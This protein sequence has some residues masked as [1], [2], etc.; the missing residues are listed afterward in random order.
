MKPERMLFLL[1]R[2]RWF[3]FGMASVIMAHATLDPQTWLLIVPLAG[4]VQC[5]YLVES[6]NRRLVEAE[7]RRKL[8]QY[9]PS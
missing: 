2:I 8:S 5:T 9:D 4:C 1:P 3:F 6:S 7:N